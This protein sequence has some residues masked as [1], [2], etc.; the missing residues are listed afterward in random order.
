MIII[1]NFEEDF[2]FVWAV[3]ELFNPQRQQIAVLVTLYCN[4]IKPA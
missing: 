4:T 2:T 3:F 1:Y